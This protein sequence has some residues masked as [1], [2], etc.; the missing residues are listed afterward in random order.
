MCVWCRSWASLSLSLSVDFSF[1]MSAN[2]K[3]I[4]IIVD[5]IPT[6]LIVEIV[7][8]KSI[9]TAQDTHTTWLYAHTHSYMRAYTD[10]LALAAAVLIQLT[11][12]KSQ[13]GTLQCWLCPVI[14]LSCI[15]DYNRIYYYPFSVNII[16]KPY[17][18]SFSKQNYCA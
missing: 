12:I 7:S 2:V 1:I 5:Q 15:S 16:P 3:L 13:K 14:C 9:T 11:V 8:P 4:T 10:V 18:Y 17:S 6:G